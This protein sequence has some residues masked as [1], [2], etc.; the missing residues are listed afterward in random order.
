MLSIPEHELKKLFPHIRDTSIFYREPDNDEDFILNFLPSALWRICNLYTIIDKGGNK[1]PFRPN[2]AQLIVLA[3]RHNRKVILKSR[4]Q[5]ISTLHLIKAMDKAIFNDNMTCGLMAQGLD[6]AAELLNKARV[7]W[8]ELDE[9]IKSFIG[10]ELES[11]NAKKFGFTNGSKL[12]IRT[13]FRSGTLQLLHVSELGKISAKFPD[14]AKELKTGTFQAVRADQEIILESTA[15]GKSGLFYDIWETATHHSGD[16][17]D[18]DF[19][20][21]FLSWIDDPDCSLNVPRVIDTTAQ[22]YFDKLERQNISLT[23]QQK[24]WWV[25]KFKELGDEI[26]QEYPATPEEAFMATRDGAYY[27]KHMTNLRKQNRIVSSLY[28]PNLDVY[29]AMDLGMS[30]DMSIVFFQV[31]RNS[32]GVEELRIFDEYVNSGEGVLHYVNVIKAKPY[33]VRQIFLPHD[34][35]V[36]E[37]GT[38]KSRYEVFRSLGA[39][40]QIV[41]S[42]S[43]ED[44]I[45]AV[46]TT[47]AST[48]ID[49]KCS[50]VIGALDNYSKEWDDIR[51]VWKNKPLHN[52]WSHMADA[53]RYM[54]ISGAKHSSGGASKKIRYPRGFAV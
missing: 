31:F 41:R 43:I 20:P 23:Q 49:E 19:L 14:K 5:G 11:D 1:I 39:P 48:W 51:G 17:T 8:E 25:A 53:L 28:D 52:K 26:Y 22:K 38:G 30:D 50:E 21:I 27:S 7:A 3:K 37:L 29:A 35:R 33:Y 54:A 6:E 36:R 32:E 18:M 47:L 12:L 44:G 13:S 2:R 9:N 45:E 15:E 40:V 42:M 10:V 46:R 4:Q 16:L 24:W 34:A